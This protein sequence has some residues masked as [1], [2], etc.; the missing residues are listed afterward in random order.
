L[1]GQH[2]IRFLNNEDYHKIDEFLAE[3]FP[4][5]KKTA[6]DLEIL[7]LEIAKY[8]SY[9][10]FKPSVS[11]NGDWLTIE[12]DAPAILAQQPDY[13]KVITLCEK[14]RY[15][16]AKPILKKLIELNP[17]NSEYHRI[18]GQ[19]LSDEGDQEEAINYLI[20]ALR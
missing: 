20:D 17:T 2:H 7:K 19:I 6:S 18:M 13:K 8:Y 12:I 10:P 1:P 3:L 9:G 14:G 16:E 11:I 5:Y 4:Q 15:Q